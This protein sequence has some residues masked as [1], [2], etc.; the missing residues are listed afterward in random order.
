MYLED[1]G[2]PVACS[3]KTS[4]ASFFSELLLF[5]TDCE[6]EEGRKRLAVELLVFV[7]SSLHRDAFALFEA[8]QVL[9]RR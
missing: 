7:L 9:Q 8:L 5:T 6:E 1:P 4:D 2:F 3:S